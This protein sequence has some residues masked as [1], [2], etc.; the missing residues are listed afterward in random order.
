M[1]SP[2]MQDTCRTLDK[3]M[4]VVIGRTERKYCTLYQMWPLYACVQDCSMWV[5]HTGS[6]VTTCGKVQSS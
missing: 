1:S 5:L 6:A 2:H 3:I 4:A